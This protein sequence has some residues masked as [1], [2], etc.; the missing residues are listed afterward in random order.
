[1]LGQNLSGHPGRAKFFYGAEATVWLSSAG[2]RVLSHLR[3]NDVRE[4]ARI[5]GQADPQ[6]HSDTYFQLLSDYPSSDV[7]NIAIRD[8]A[9]VIYPD[10]RW[11]QLAYT[12]AHSIRGEQE[13]HWPDYAT[14][15]EFQLIR[16]DAL[17][18]RRRSVLVTGWAV[19]NRLVSAIDAARAYPK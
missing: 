4:F 16:H 18:A 1:G 3:F 13:W 12:D 17:S 11:A 6:D 10:D 14:R 2:F 19:V 15:R 8:E 5:R 7:Y 9:R